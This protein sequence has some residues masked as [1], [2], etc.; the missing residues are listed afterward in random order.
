MIKCL[1]CGKELRVIKHTHLRFKCSGKLKN[2]QEYKEKY[3]LAET[4]D[5]DLRQQTAV[6]EENMIKKYGLEEGLIRWNTY[7]DKQAQTNSFEHFE[8]TRGWSLTEFDE[9]N[10]SRAVTLKNLELKH[11]QEEGKKVFENYCK[12]QS[13]AGNKLEHFIDKYGDEEGTK[14]FNIVCKQK[15]LT[16]ENFIRKYGDEEGL[17]KY[18]KNLETRKGNFVSTVGKEFV[19]NVVDLIPNHW[20]FHEGVYGK[21]FCVFK[22][23]PYFYD[24]V[25]TYP[26]LACVEFNGNYWHANPELYN[27]DEIIQ[28]PNQQFLTASDIWLRDEKK[29]QIIKDRGY[30]VL[31]VWEK[32]Y[33]ENNI[34]TIKKVIE[35]LQ[36]IENE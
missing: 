10:K 2:L 3:P 27:P 17:I 7:R 4:M 14:K 32:D 29:N 23:R 1:E 15:G 18:H 12:K 5:A 11:G 33:K 36:L 9:Y 20:I 30:E 8:K 21:E 19:N 16:L 22:D 34:E 26:F 28:Y 6:T 13:V 25:V 24:F 35:W 31:V